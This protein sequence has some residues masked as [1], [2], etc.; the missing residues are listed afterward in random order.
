MEYNPLGDSLQKTGITSGNG[1]FRISFSNP[2]ILYFD[3]KFYSN[4][5]INVMDLKSEIVNNII[6]SQAQ[7]ELKEVI[8]NERNLFSINKIELRIRKPPKSQAPIIQN[9]IKSITGISPS[10]NQYKYLGKT[11]LYYI[12]GVKVESSFIKESVTETFEKLEIISAPDGEYWFKAS[13]VIFNFIS[14]KIRNPVIGVQT[15]SEFGILFPYLSQNIGIYSMGKKASFRASSIY[16]SYEQDDQSSISQEINQIT[17]SSVHQTQSTTSPNFNTFIFNYKLDSLTTVSYHLSQQN[18]HHSQHNNFTFSSLTSEDL[19]FF[20]ST[21]NRAY[22][23]AKIGQL[24]L[25]KRQNH[26]LFMRYDFGETN[27]KNQYLDQSELIQL[28]S[29]K[30]NSSYINYAYRAQ[31]SK[32]LKL[33]TTISWENKNATANYKIQNGNPSFST[34]NSSFIGLKAIIT[35]S[36]DKLSIL[37]GGRIDLINQEFESNSTQ[38]KRTNQIRILPTFSLQ[39]ESEKFGNYNLSANSDYVLP[40]ISQLATFSRRLDPYKNIIGNNVLEPENSFAFNLTHTINA[41]PFNLTSDIGYNET[42]NQL[43]YS[44][45]QLEGNQLIQQ[46]TNVGKSKKIT[47]L[48]NAGLPITK[49][50]TSQLTVAQKIVQYKLNPTWNYTNFHSNWTP[51]FSISNSWEFQFST[52][53]STSLSF[54]FD[55]FEYAFYETKRYFTPNTSITL[56]GTFGRDWYISLLWNTIFANANKEK[57][58]LSQQFYNSSLNYISNY[59]YVSF[60][61]QKAFGKKLNNVPESST[62]DEVKRKFKSF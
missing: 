42:N 4:H 56:N 25:F 24:I 11:I 39:Y 16:Y 21:S 22:Q 32:R 28:T 30:S 6:L 5:R 29:E 33:N 34:F 48:V 14:K 8:V 1:D 58:T 45:Y 51:I 12:D 52:K 49:S 41:N 54:Y 38:Y 60:S 44:P 27:I 35:S 15:N 9:F 17:S 3:S 57:T 18:I 19:P 47:L 53:F 61:I 59:R 26:K 62:A 20:Q 40:D 55:N 2:T 36:F 31:L 43:G 13:E 23:K 37:F 7:N 10:S 50:L 46:Y